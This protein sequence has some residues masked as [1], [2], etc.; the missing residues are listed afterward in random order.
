MKIVNYHK[1]GTISNITYKSLKGEDC[2]AYKI[3][4]KTVYDL[5]LLGIVLQHKEEINVVPFL[6]KTKDAAKEFLEF[7]IKDI[8]DYIFKNCEETGHTA[9]YETYEIEIETNAGKNIKAYAFLDKNCMKLYK[10]VSFS[11]CYKSISRDA[12]YEVLIDGYANNICIEK[13]S[14][15]N[16]VSK[17][18]PGKIYFKSLKE[19]ID[20]YKDTKEDDITYE[21]IEKNS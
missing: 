21:L 15:L 10:G 4:Y 18:K 1:Y 9:I 8:T 13:Y 20:N 17:A 7:K 16:D 6:F 12:Y 2:S 5:A 19:Y 14:N 11:S 3:T